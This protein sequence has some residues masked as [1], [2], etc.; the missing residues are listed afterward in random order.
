MKHYKHVNIEIEYDDTAPDPYKEFDMLGEVAAYDRRSAYPDTEGMGK[1]HYM[2]APQNVTLE[3]YLRTKADAVITVDFMGIGLAY[4]TRQQIIA[5][6]GAYTPATSRKAKKVL[7]AQA[8]EYR[9]WADG[10]TY[11]YIITN[12]DGD[13]LDSCYG[14]YGRDY[15]EQEARA[16]A[17]YHEKEIQANQDAITARFE[18]VTT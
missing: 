14:F 9:L 16:A 11:G 5:E 10:E 4:V 12:N 13:R 15:C 1:S 18:L 2:Y 3:K 6:Y 8:E 7:T 17:D